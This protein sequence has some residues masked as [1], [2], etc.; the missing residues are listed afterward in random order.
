MSKIRAL[1][2]LTIFC[3]VASASMFGAMAFSGEVERNASQRSMVAFLVVLASGFSTAFVTFDEKLKVRTPGSYSRWHRNIIVTGLVALF[4]GGLGFSIQMANFLSGYDAV[5]F[6]SARLLGI[7]SLVFGL[8][9][10]IAV[11]L[12]L[13]RTYK[14][15]P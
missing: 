11:I 12:E 15:M 3:F 9:V 1:Y 4:C 8:V 2:L 10:G 14:S 5:Q 7:S 13:V 6:V